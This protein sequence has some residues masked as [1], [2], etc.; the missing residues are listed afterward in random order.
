MKANLIDQLCLKQSW[1]DRMAVVVSLRPAFPR[2]LQRVARHL[3]QFRA[4]RTALGRF[5][6]ARP[7]RA[8]GSRA[9]RR[10]K[11]KDRGTH[12]LRPPRI[13]ATAAHPRCVDLPPP[14]LRRTAALRDAHH[15]HR[16]PRAAHD[17]LVRQRGRRRG[18]L[19]RRHGAVRPAER[20]ARRPFRP[21]R[22]PAPRGPSPRRLRERADRAGAGGRAPVGTVRRRR[23]DRRLDPADRPH[24]AGP[25]GGDAGGDPRP[26]RL[27]A[28]VHRGR[29][30][31]GDGR[32]H[33]RARPGDRHRAVH[34]RAPGGRTDHGS[35]PDPGRRPVLR[36]A[37]RHPARP[38]RRG[39]RGRTARL[40]ALRAGCA[41]PGR[42][43]PGHRR[44][45]RR[46]AGLAD[47]VLR[48]DRPP[49]GERC[50]L[51]DLRGGQHAGR[52]RLR[53]HRLEEQPA[54]CG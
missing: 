33:F 29:V 12:G 35:R 14:G 28:D 1:R 44:G 15:R 37:A 53:R 13:R 54:P 6:P 4:K 36:R 39:H 48:G 27:S 19:R 50:P 25:L 10:Q 34:R 49:R 23:A 43:L 45:L 32:V 24:G 7:T 42:H 16:P 52:H 2:R 5:R 41:R 51:R 38:A 20:Q 26:A 46:H 47:R 3:P 8:P 31:V 17:R 21:A 30:R 40:G 18:G 11:G 22:G 9:T